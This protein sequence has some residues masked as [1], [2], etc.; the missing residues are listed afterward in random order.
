MKSPQQREAIAER[1][2]LALAKLEQ[3]WQ[4]KTIG[5]GFSCDT[6]TGRIRLSFEV[7][8]DPAFTLTVTANVEDVK[9]GNGP[10]N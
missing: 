2:A 3:S 7:P 9:V 1:L 6:E 4:G 5:I 8:R 10:E